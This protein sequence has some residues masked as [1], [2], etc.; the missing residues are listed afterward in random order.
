MGKFSEE[1]R[2]KIKGLHSDVDPDP[3][4]QKD[5]QK[6]KSEEVSCFEVL[7]VFS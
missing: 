1:P 2:Q 3:G 6:R 5:P 7:D 4:G